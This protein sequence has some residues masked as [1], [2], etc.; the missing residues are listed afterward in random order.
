MRTVYEGYTR[1][2]QKCME[3]ISGR[4]RWGAGRKTMSNGSLIISLH[5]SETIGDDLGGP[6]FD[7]V[8][9]NAKIVKN[10]VFF[11]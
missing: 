3:K 6:R 2:V 4:N 8:R 5:G 9:K 1:G 7:L 10:V 11:K